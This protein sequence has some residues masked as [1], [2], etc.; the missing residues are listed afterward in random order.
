MA[1]VS[2]GTSPS[3]ATRTSTRAPSLS[4]SSSALGRLEPK[5]RRGQAGGQ[6]SL[7][8]ERPPTHSRRC[9]KRAKGTAAPSPR[10]AEEE[11]EAE[12]A[13]EEAAGARRIAATLV[14]LA[15]SLIL[16][17]PTLVTLA[18]SLILIGPT[19]AGRPWRSAG[20]PMRSPRGTAAATVAA[21][22]IER[23][24]NERRASH[25][26]VRARK[27]TGSGRGVVAFILCNDLTIHS[28][29]PDE[30]QTGRVELHVI[31][32]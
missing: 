20:A 19:A 15:E 17:G 24:A 9:R 26:R 7:E 2:V 6:S 30:Y 13:E 8:Y 32:V 3:S 27:R 28:Y 10:A 18:E 4:S 25:G 31:L 14:T 16:I 11:E 12:E 23:T 21:R 29:E 1:A 5:A 22:V